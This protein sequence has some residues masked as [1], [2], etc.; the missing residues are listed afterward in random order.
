MT[1]YS[2][3]YT[4]TNLICIG[5]L[6]FI[7]F[8][9]I[10]E[11]QRAAEVFYYSFAII[12]TFFYCIIDIVAAMC[13]NM[14]FPGVRIVLLLMNTIYI[15]IPLIMSVT[16][17]KYVTTRMARYGYKRGNLGLVIKI[18]VYVMLI[19]TLSTPLTQF[20]FYLDDKNQ[21]HRVAGAYIVPFFCWMN[22]IYVSL[23]LRCL[24]KH[25]D[26]IEGQ[27]AAGVLR[28]FVISTMVCSIIQV[29]IYG[30]TCAQIGYT[31]SLLIV[32]MFNQQNKISIDE[33]TGLSNRREFEVQLNHSSKSA[34]TL[35]LSMIDVDQ[36]KEIN[37]RFGH[38]EGDNA[39]KQIAE[40]LLKACSQCEGSSMAARYGGDEFVIL[41]RDCTE[42][43]KDIL[44]KVI[45][46][47]LNKINETKDSS[48]EL[49]VSIGITFEVI[50]DQHDIGDIMKKADRDMYKN[51]K[52]KAVLRKRGI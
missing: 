47:E 29:L 34:K 45:H 9:Y 7:L 51:K 22:L 3:Y 8:A 1:V 35:L 18:L 10:K 25:I 17:E 5:L 16:W 27:R 33:L 23:K 48:Y 13:K 11:M 14:S 38:A 52:E 39:L 41:V 44:V 28:V 42:K 26:S 21:Y 2:I 40:C 49:S 50:D 19:V 46:A 31:F 6:A 30:C 4:E 32:Y 43:T 37:D 15:V 12:Q 20:A 36:F 24:K